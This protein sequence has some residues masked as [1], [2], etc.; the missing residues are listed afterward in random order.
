M[1]IASYGP[2]KV[3]YLLTTDNNDININKLSYKVDTLN[4]NS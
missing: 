1:Q 4:G 2:T 3:Q